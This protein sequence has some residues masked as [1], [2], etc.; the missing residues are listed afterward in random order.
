M[1][2]THYIFCVA[3]FMVL[4]ATIFPFQHTYA[5]KEGVK[6]PEGN[7]FKHSYQFPER[8]SGS[9]FAEKPSFFDRSYISI[10]IGMEEISGMSEWLGSQTTGITANL[11]YGYWLAPVHG[12]E[13][14]LGYGNLP[15]AG[16]KQNSEGEAFHTSESAKYFSMGINYLFNFT[17]FASKLERPRR[18]ELIGLFG[19][20]FRKK[21]EFSI[22]LNAGMRVQYN[23]ARNVSVFIEPSISVFNNER[24][25]KNEGDRLNVYAMPSASLGFSVSLNS[26]QKGFKSLSEK[27]RLSAEKGLLT[28]F[29]IKTNLLYDATGSMNLGFEV[30]LGEK[31]TL[32]VSGNYNPWTIDEVTNSK[33]KHILVQPEFRYWIGERFKGHFFGSHAH[34]AYYNVGGE[35]WLTNLAEWSTGENLKDYRHE[36]WLAGVGVSYGYLWRIARRWGLEGTVGFGYAYMDYEK[37]D[38]SSCSMMEKKDTNHYFGP[39]KVGLSLIFMIK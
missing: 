8:W 5:Q 13:M 33:A 19:G 31:T 39:T 2:R 16:F 25:R 34:Y 3:L 21:E 37:Y 4:G 1:S 9:K 29:A 35:N 10:G 17:S 18:W 32:D 38:C 24:Y 6:Q 30:G 27:A 12:L 28:R 36:G 20:S 14:K 22:G 15:Y 11:T 23:I 7:I 26:I